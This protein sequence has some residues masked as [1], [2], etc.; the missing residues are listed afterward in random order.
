MAMYIIYHLH[1]YLS[2]FQKAV[3]LSPFRAKELYQAFPEIEGDQVAGVLRLLVR[4]KPSVIP[5]SKLT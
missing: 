2:L 4:T 1:L 3:H 5:S